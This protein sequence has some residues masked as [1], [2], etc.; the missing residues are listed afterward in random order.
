MGGKGGRFGGRGA[1][2]TAFGASEDEGPPDDEAALLAKEQLK[3]AAK[4]KREELKEQRDFEARHQYEELKQLRQQADSISRKK[5]ELLQGQIDQFRGMMS[6]VEK[7]CGSDEVEKARMIDS[8]ESKVM[9]LQASLQAVRNGQTDPSEAEGAG[10]GYKGGGYKGGGGRG[11]KGGSYRGGGGYKGAGG[12]G[13]KGSGG[14]GGKGRGERSLDNRSKALVV[15][16]A[17][18]DFLGSAHAHFSK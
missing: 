2:E 17:P 16:G 15:S 12:R 5:E 4:A 18:P 3:L 7:I 9:S 8:L 13:Y 1:Q 6:K 10:R 11:Y 14:R